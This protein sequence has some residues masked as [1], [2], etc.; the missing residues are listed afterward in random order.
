MLQKKNPNHPI[1]VDNLNGNCIPLLLSDFKVPLLHFSKQVQTGG[2]IF[3]LFWLV[4][5]FGLLCFK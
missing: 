4:G 5:W 3:V 1:V 2:F